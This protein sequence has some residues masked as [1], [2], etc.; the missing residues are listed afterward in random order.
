[1][2][3]KSF[4]DAAYQAAVAVDAIVEAANYVKSQCATF[5][6]DQPKDILEQLDEGWMLRYHEKHPSNYY[7]YIDKNLVQV[8]KPTGKTATKEIGIYQAMAFSQQAYG[9]MRHTDPL[10]HKI[11]GEWR[12]KWSKYRKNR[13]TDLINK[14]KEDTKTEKAAVDAFT[15]WLSDTVFPNMV[16][17]NKT[18]H[19]R[20]DDTAMP[21]DLL[22]RKI[23]AFHAAK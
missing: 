21:D 22:K 6:E 13:L 5:V 19:A 18:S 11:I 16:K 20:G 4:K 12:T 9:Q 3:I 10:L 17:R 15:K 2:T 1:M 8:D 7:A 14:M 23:A